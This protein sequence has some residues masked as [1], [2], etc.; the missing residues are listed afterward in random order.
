MRASLLWSILLCVTV[1]AL[2]GRL[3]DWLIGPSFLPGLLLGALYGLVFALLTARRA[4]SPGAG[5]LWGLGYAFLLWLAFPAT[6]VPYCAGAG[7]RMGELDMVRSH[8]PELVAY[9]LC[10]GMPLGIGL[11]TLGLFQQ[12]QQE[13]VPF[14][15][16]R[17]LLVGGLAGLVGGWIFG[18]AMERA[19]FL[20]LVA[21][22]VHAGSGVLGFS[23]HLFIS[24]L[25]GAGFGLLFQRDLR[26]YG[27]SLG[28]GTAY[29]MLWWFLGPLTFLPLSQGEPLD[30][31]YDSG[32]V[33]FGSFVGHIVFGLLVGLIYAAVDRLWIGFFTESDPIHREPEGAGSRVLYSLEWGALASL[34]GGLLFTLILLAIGFLPKVASLVG[35]SSVAYGF[36]VNMVVS[37]LIGMSYGVLF[38]HEAP[39]FGSGVAWGMLYG[40]IWWFLGQLTLMPL[41]LGGSLDWNVEAAAQLLPSLIGH[42]IY[43]AVTASIFLT[44]ERRHAEWLLLD[45]RIAAREA[46]RRRPVG[47]PAPAL[48]LFVL[49]LGVLMPILVG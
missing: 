22:L 46:R 35:S 13:Q 47:T 43:G 15:L 49:G 14:S 7:V 16:V 32:N 2:G 28:W 17:A 33:L 29:G 42:L 41:M 39:D 8:F 5:L 11:G 34:V 21:G 38:R 23:V 44:L 1:G 48:W 10:F 18:R 4:L 24:M 9:V 20:P 37:A 26:G 36:I 45:P 3:A 30:W 40:L 25:M 12:Q 6:V 31:S 27:S 19:G